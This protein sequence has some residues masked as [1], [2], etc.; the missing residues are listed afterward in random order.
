[1]GNLFDGPM[2]RPR[3]GKAPAMAN[4]PVPFHADSPPQLEAVI[5]VCPRRAK[6]LR[7][8]LHFLRQ[9]GPAT[10]REISVGCEMGRSTVCPCMN[11]AERCGWVAIVGNKLDSLSKIHVQLYS[12]TAAGLLALG[13]KAN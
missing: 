3:F 11:T 10:Q 8:A 9:G 7:R 12:I 2:P 13:V 5:V 4:I 6:Q 1:M